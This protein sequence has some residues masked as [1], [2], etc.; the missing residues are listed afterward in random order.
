MSSSLFSA[1]SGMR[2][3]QQWIDVIG[4]NLANSNTA[5]FKSTRASFS[6]AMSQNLRYA[7][8]PT[9]GSGGIN[10]SQLGLGV[11]N[12][13]TQRIFNQGS[14][15]TTGRTLDLALEGNGYFSVGNGQE[16]FYTRAGAFGLDANSSLVDLV[17]GFQVKDTAG[18]SIQLDVEA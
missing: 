12:V 1:L 10:P 16:N 15:D 14:L 3:H 7:S 13:N 11:Q 2:S 5:G 9:G 17:T 8:A 4:N 6:A 18:A